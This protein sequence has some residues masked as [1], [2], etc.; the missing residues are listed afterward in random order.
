MAA[1]FWVTQ[2][3]SGAIVSVAS[4]PQVRLTVASTTGMTT[5]DVRT[6][7]GV[8]GTTEA[9]GTWTITVID[10]THID[11]QGTTFAN[12]YTSGG[13]V[14]GKWSSTNANNWV[15]TTGGTNYGQTV[16]GSADTVTFDTNSGAGT[17]TVDS[18]I[19]GL[20]LV[21]L[22][23]GAYVA[24]GTLDGLTNGPI[25]LTITSS[26]SFSGNV[27]HTISWSGTFTFTAG[28]GVT[29]FDITNTTGATINISGLNTV[30]NYTGAI[31]S[32][33]IINTGGKTLGTLTV[34]GSSNGVGLLLQGG[35]T[36][37]SMTLNGTNAIQVSTSFAVTGAFTIAA[38]VSSPVLFGVSNSWGASLSTI[39]VTLGSASIVGAVLKNVIFAGA[40]VFATQSIDLGNNNMNGGS[41]TPPSGGGAGIIGS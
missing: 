41:I 30:F 28:A 25:N 24:G 6:V 34:N 19:N 8:A 12:L 39:T 11:L 35:G 36:F 33:R 5:G 1:R 14:N 4:P 22:N 32:G 31:N 37:A 27:A 26:A 15:S 23:A 7:F 2:P 40:A 10:S 21:S 29:T 9:N 18:T 3:V 13:S 20:S 38:S 16:P 17:V